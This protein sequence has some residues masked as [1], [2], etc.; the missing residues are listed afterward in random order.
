MSDNRIHL[1]T[2][3][4]A[5]LQRVADDGSTTTLLDSSKLLALLTYLNA[6][7]GRSATRDHLV[8]LL[9]SDLEEEGG[10]HALRHHL[11]LLKSKLADV[12]A[13]DRGETL[14]LREPIPCD[15]D[16]LNAASRDGDLIKVV[17]LY[18]GD[19]FP[20][21]AAVGAHEFEHWTER[22]R[23][24]LRSVFV[25]SGQ[26]VVKQ[27]L[28][29]GRSRDA[30]ALARRVRDADPFDQG[31][32]RLLLETLVAGRDVVGA[33]V[34]VDALEHLAR[35]EELTLEGSTV[36]VID[37]VRHPAKRATATDER[38]PGLLSQELVG[39]E[40]E[41]AALVRH[42]DETLRGNIQG[43][44]LTGP[45][46]MGKTRLLRDFGARLASMRRDVV[47]ARADWA[48][49]TI[50]WSFVSDLIA[51]LCTLP[52][53]LGVAP[54][55]ASVL[56]GLAP[57]A[58]A[59]FR[60]VSVHPDQS[61]EAVVRRGALRELLKALA[62]ER[63]LA[64]L[65]DDMHWCDGTSRDVLLSALEGIGRHRLLVI[66]AERDQMTRGVPR[67]FATLPLTPLSHQS[68]TTLVASI[69][70][71]P[72]APWAASLCDRLAREVG[73]SPLHLLET[74]QLATERGAL[75][76][77][78]GTWIL[79]D[80]SLLGTLLDSGEALRAR[81]N[82][83][84]N[85]QRSCVRLLACIG[86]PLSVDTLAEC[87]DIPESVALEVV[88]ELE[89]SGILR[90]TGDGVCLAHDE[91]ADAVRRDVSEE[92]RQ[93]LVGRAG[94]VLAREV[95][96]RI[97]MVRTAALLIDAN[98]RDDLVE[99]CER[100][101]KTARA[102]GDR[103][104][105]ERVVA[106]LLA[107]QSEPR[108]RERLTARLP[109]WRRL[110]LDLP[111]RRAVA[112]SLAVAAITLAVSASQADA[113][114]AAT[115]VVARA[116]DSVGNV[117][118]TRYEL[119]AAWATSTAPIRL[120]RVT[121]PLRIELSGVQSV[122]L[123]PHD[124]L[125]YLLVRQ[126]SDSGLTDIFEYR[127]G[128]PLLRITST[129]GDDVDPEWA[130][131]GSAIA[132]TTSR[133]SK[134]GRRD[135]A[136]LDRRTGRI[137]RVTFSLA[138]EHY[139][140]WSPDGTT[141]AFMHDADEGESESLCLAAVDGGDLR[142]EGLG[143]GSITIVAWTS[144]AEL[145]L[146]MTGEVGGG[147]LYRYHVGSRLLTR[148]SAREGVYRY[149]S[150]A[151]T[152]C[153]CLD[154]LSGSRFWSLASMSVG[155]RPLDLVF[156]EDDRASLVDVHALMRM[157]GRWIERIDVPDSVTIT[158]GVPHRVVAAGRRADLS[159]VSMPA[160]RWASTDTSA[161]TV[162]SGGELVG[163]RAGRHARVTVSAGG[164]RSSTFQVIVRAPETAR[165]IRE[166]WT[167]G[168]G[169]TWRPFGEP[170]PV[171]RSQADGSAAL[172]N[173]GDGVYNSG[174][175]TRLVYPTHGGLAVRARLASQ[176]T[177]PQWQSQR[178]GLNGDLTPTALARWDHR[179]GYLWSAE[180]LAGARFACAFEFPAGPEGPEWSRQI[181]AADISVP[182]VSLHLATGAWFEVVVQWL[183]DGRCAVLL[184]GALLALSQTVQKADSARL[185]MYG[186]SVAT[187]VLLGPLEVWRGVL[188]EVARALIQ[189]R[190]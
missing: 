145:L 149:I 43:V 126:V 82:A 176:I 96:D 59:V 31:G 171:I 118:L 88:G 85:R 68:V 130:P 11:W 55:T 140:R 163:I 138:T 54:R 160:L 167:T 186:N 2:L 77:T 142:C 119:P 162:T 33:A 139:L 36:A 6:A 182:N 112:T 137:T 81:V 102:N 28:D 53:A 97:A 104:S 121:R 124:S 129:P 136:V 18:R 87:T 79:G 22:E 115:V 51:Q 86:T 61:A 58:S 73:G 91:I 70:Q 60:S 37:S 128:A 57:S 133:W 100:F 190:R 159:L 168:I 62:E 108:E 45:A 120:R 132:F 78:D 69:A 5:A 3:G 158:L 150:E 117:I 93:R 35:E 187:D 26:I 20:N 161:V 89:R 146:S 17:S 184:D 8:H 153:Y 131:D 15:R 166:D 135:V 30:A 179:T 40:A 24:T 12:I 32:W 156:G 106:D 180:R 152:I 47:P 147:G 14:T 95:S 1:R 25:R 66:V 113:P 103:R 44:H 101:V 65:L 105:L 16:E 74:L 165:L 189:M 34:E 13:I 71:L 114:T 50:E 83:L 169:S 173:N 148:I 157:T 75:R 125:P 116:I 39:R 188:P 143:T 98:R 144:D 72:E 134:L 109:W 76:V 127:P 155:S 52:G 111:L 49:R 92:E 56:V 42:W 4:A 172:S 90:H 10:R 99:L 181:N 141:L 67:S 110:G 177:M 19:F 175:Y 38:V 178:L 41:F 48:S 63:P 80:A 27:W 123:P 185:V 107:F 29:L 7:P 151:A 183:P 174:V 94:S 154:S 170:Q 64:L 9:W 21:F 122:T 84:S 23:A 164:W 46:G